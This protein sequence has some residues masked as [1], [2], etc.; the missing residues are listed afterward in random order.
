MSSE[1][2]K[3][4]ELFI[5]DGTGKKPK[6]ILSK[7]LASSDFGKEFSHDVYLDFV[8]DGVSKAKYSEIKVKVGQVIPV[9][10][11]PVITTDESISVK[12]DTAVKLA[13][14]F[15]DP[16]GKAVSIKWENTAG[17]VTFAQQTSGDTSWC[18]FNSGPTDATFSFRIT[19]TDDLGAQSFKNIQVIVGKEPEPKP[20]IKIGQT[21][22][23]HGTFKALEML[24][25]REA[26]DL[27]LVTGD[28]TDTEVDDD[29]FIAA[30]NSLGLVYGQN[31]LNAEGNH[32]SPEEGGEGAQEDLETA[33]P[34]LK[35]TQ[36]LQ[37]MQKG[38][39]A[40]IVNN[41]QINGYSQ[42]DSV[43]S[44]HVF[45]SLEAVKQLRAEGKID[46]VIFM[47]H[48]PMYNLQ[49]GH[50][51]EYNFRY[52]HHAAMD[53]AGVDFYISG[54]IHNNQR[55]VPIKFGGEGT[56]V[57][58]VINDKM[59][60]DAHDMTTIPHGI[61]CIVNGS[62]VKSHTLSEKSN[63]W[64]PYAADD[65][66]AYTIFEFNGKNVTVKF[67]D[68]DSGSVLH[69]FKATKGEGE[70]E[71][72][73]CPAGQHW[74]EQ[75][76]RCV[77]DVVTCPQGE[78]YD[79]VQGRCVPDDVQ[80]D[81]EV[82]QYG[83]KWL[84]GT[85]E[86]SVITMSRDTATDD[87]WSGNVKGLQLGYE[88]TFIGKSIGTNN[89]SHFAMKCFGGN[90]SKGDW[91]NQRWY[92]LG[93]RFDGEIQLQWEGP[94]PNNHDFVLPERCQFIK[95]LSKGLEGNFI[96]LKW[97]IM[98]LAGPSGSPSNGGVRCRMWVGENPLDANNKPT[99]DWKLAFDFI[100]G[101][102]VNV[103]DPQSFSAPD[104]QD[105][106]VRRSDTERH[107]VYGLGTIVTNAQD[108][109]PALRVRAI[110]STASQLVKTASLSE[111]HMIE[112]D[113][114]DDSKDKSRTKQKK[115]S[116]AKRKQH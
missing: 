14:Q 86:Q 15:S 108:G 79:P 19:A 27:I 84:V 6:K 74:S 21:G 99:N 58:P 112:E 45:K 33:Y 55:T 115:N 12:T 60:G 52:V 62:A 38:N 102:D 25:T 13:A 106:E 72:H 71:P 63:A 54:H 22:D 103:I 80:P 89:S 24:K 61:I 110:T 53:A 78:H 85:G 96:G 51:P 105:C 64:T 109:T 104:E 50:D 114:D 34:V 100:D 113:D 32:E 68:I 95:K 37:L 67:V 48:K 97:A 10:K 77:Q 42:L 101:K 41:T 43:A 30:A 57:P 29:G 7:K 90:H 35:E 69:T 70:P 87:R 26:C 94:H 2:I 111:G 9:N 44:K 88:A 65:T 39:V 40:V 81:G 18:D 93:I 23:L 31:Q 91:Q 36:W 83:I 4:Y 73:P 98:K 8:S 3:K 92:D 76:Q 116:K 82:D 46:W 59:V 56:N 107:D 75:E 47:Q 66:D 28:V 17:N 49:G 1:N 11:P 5:D 20:Q 16:E